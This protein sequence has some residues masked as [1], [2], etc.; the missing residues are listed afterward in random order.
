[1][2]A[3]SLMMS[4]NAASQ[5]ETPVGELDRVIAELRDKATEFARLAPREKAQ[6]LREQIPALR[7]VVEGW[8][9]SACQ[10]KGID[11]ATPMAG[12]EWLAGPA[13]T[14]RNLRLLGQSL[15][16]I[17]ASGR[18]P[19]GRAV[20]T[21]SLAGEARVEA[22]VF[23]G[24]AHD[25]ALFSG[26]SARVLF[27]PGLDEAAVRERQASFY[28]RRDP[29]G[30]VSLVLG[31]GNVASIPPMDALYK[32][33]VDGNVCLLKMNPVNEYLGPH[34]ERGFAPLIRRG[35]LRIVY[36]G[37]E[38][39]KYLVEHPGIDDIHITGSDRTHDL[40]VWGPP[41]PE[42]E[43]RRAANQ[44]LLQKS[45]T[46]ELGNVSPVAIVPANYSDVELWFQAR[47]V[48][49]M[50]ANNGSFNCNAAKMLITAADW[51]QRDEFHRLLVR[52][53]GAA[54]LRRA[55][56][57][58]AH[59]RYR[60]LTEG[61]TCER[62]GE[63]GADQI[64][65]TLISGVDSATPDEKLFH[66]EPFCGILTETALPAREPE[67][68]L[69]AATHFMN[70]RLWGTLNAAIVIHPGHERDPV[71]GQAL[72]HA[73]RD[74]RYGT[75]AINHWPALGYGLVT[76]PWGGHP[77]ATLG[78]IQS[79]LGWVHNT[80]L[81]E[82]I[83]KSVVRGPLVARPKPAW[84]VDNRATDRIGRKLV[85]F[86]AAPSWFRVPGMALA[87]LGG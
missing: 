12:E 30:G 40:I 80:F 53:L 24:S 84:F 66:T 60:Q 2:S 14:M 19:L 44:P 31:A 15:E 52:A 49:S 56:Y 22:D 78:N 83:E 37:G 58:G 13:T 68:F 45:I 47:S 65:W 6:L 4:G 18:P 87:A 16:Q 51:A 39:G 43:R 26:F 25:A 46:S 33:F 85:A 42:R 48:A 10:A 3:Q 57:P 73:V 70:D 59:D 54:P 72:D 11:P 34:F 76:P 21:R 74:L 67:A 82:G 81:L 79:G 35:Y 5:A 77:S 36:G 86:E 7:A 41:G 32:L 64:A 27:Q 9:A 8:V 50:V 38:V 29:V 55:Y 1:M 62:L 61:R 69:S 23:P 75:V 20:R 28:Q 63:P 17:A 71:I